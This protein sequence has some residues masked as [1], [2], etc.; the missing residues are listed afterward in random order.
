MS[1]KEIA[2]SGH[3]LFTDCSTSLSLVG[4]VHVKQLLSIKAAQ[5]IVDRNHDGP[6]SLAEQDEFKAA[7]VVFVMSTLLA[8][9]SKHDRVC[10]DY[11]HTI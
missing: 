1:T 10:D 7:F 9:I 5:A 8:P 4:A 11:F 2:G 3:W 6:M